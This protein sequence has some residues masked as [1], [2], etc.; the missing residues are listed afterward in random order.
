MDAE[1]IIR[2]KAR[3]VAPDDGSVTT[4]AQLQQAVYDAVEKHGIL[5]LVD[6]DPEFVAIRPLNAVL[7]GSTEKP[8][9]KLV[10][11]N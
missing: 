7:L 4:L 8:K 6:Q 5:E 3:N 1:L 9:L 10:V 11:N 2:F